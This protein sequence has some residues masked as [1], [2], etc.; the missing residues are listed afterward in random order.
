MLYVDA[1]N[2]LYSMANLARTPS[3]FFIN[4]LFIFTLTMT[5]Y[6]FFRALG[7]LCSSLDVGE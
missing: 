5:M 1:T 3:Q 7:A 6:S 2:D 4:L